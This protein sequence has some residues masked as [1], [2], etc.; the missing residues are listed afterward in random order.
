MQKITTRRDGG[1]VMEYGPVGGEDK[2]NQGGNLDHHT[3]LFVQPTS[4]LLQLIKPKVKIHWLVKDEQKVLW[5]Q[6]VS[7]HSIQRLF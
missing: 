6:M 1:W 4:H 3:L 2:G 5:M 7:R